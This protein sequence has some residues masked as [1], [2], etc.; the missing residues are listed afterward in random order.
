M[1]GRSV[2][3]T[4]FYPPISRLATRRPGTAISTAR[5]SATYRAES[6]ASLPIFLQS[7]C[8]F[9]IDIARSQE[10]GARR[11][12]RLELHFRGPARAPAADGHQF[13]GKKAAGAIIAAGFSL[14]LQAI[15]AS[16]PFHERGVFFH[17]H[18]R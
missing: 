18:L 9:E 16:R 6:T 13:P 11:D 15:I 17:V 12:G 14:Q 3:K 4:N 2:R 7:A 8:G 10:P 1:C 5:S